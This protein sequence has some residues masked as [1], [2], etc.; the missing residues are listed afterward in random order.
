[1]WPNKTTAVQYSNN[2]VRPI[3]DR[4]RLDW[5]ER[6][7]DSVSI[8]KLDVDLKMWI[9]IRPIYIEGGKMPLREAIDKAIEADRAQNK[10]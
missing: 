9:G 6:N 3:T 4:E 8:M 7:D 5:I 2:Y 10:V 1:V